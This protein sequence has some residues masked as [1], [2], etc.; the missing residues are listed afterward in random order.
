[1]DEIQITKLIFGIYLSVSAAVL[2][3]IAFKL[4]YK[5][6]INDR[7][8]NKTKEKS[9]SK[10]EKIRTDLFVLAPIIIVSLPV[11]FI[12][13]FFVALVLLANSGVITIGAVRFIQTAVIHGGLG[14]LAVIIAIASIIKLARSD[15]SS[16]QIL[17]RTVMIAVCAAA[18]FFLIRPLI[19]DIP[20]LKHPETIYLGRLE[21]DHQIGIGDSLDACYL[22]GADMAGGCH[23][24]NIGEK[25]FDEGQK[26]WS[27]NNYNLFAEVTCLPHTDTL[28]TVKFNT[29]LPAAV[30]ELYPPSPDLPGD[31]ESFSIQINDSVYTLPVSI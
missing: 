11:I 25:K 12:V 15:K 22:R 18:A 3:L 20:Y 8:C 1:M 9:N 10:S 7:I 19:L 31:W 21:F 14:L 24:F 26:L 5:Y 17:G 23:L 27:E 6:L 2:L 29:K 13:V 30:T 16:R 4:Y 28:M